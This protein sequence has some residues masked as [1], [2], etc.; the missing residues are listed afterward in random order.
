MKSSKTIWSAYGN[1]FKNYFK[2]SGRASRYDFWAFKIIDMLIVL[3]LFLFSTLAPIFA[4]VAGVYNLATIFPALALLSRRLHDRG[5]SFWLWGLVVLL[6]FGAGVFS[7]I[8][9]YR[10]VRLG[11]GTIVFTILG[12]AAVIVSVYIFFQT[13]FKSEQAANKYGAAVK[14]TK[15]YE[16]RA[17]WYLA[18]YLLFAFLGAAAYGGLIAYY[19][20]QGF[21]ANVSK[22]GEQIQIL[23][24][25]IRD[26][27]N[28]D[29]NGLSPMAAVQLNLVPEDMIGEEYLINPFG[30]PV[31]LEGHGDQFV[32]IY[33]GV[34][35]KAC[36]RLNALNLGNGFSQMLISAGR[37]KS[38]DQCPDARCD[39]G[40]FFK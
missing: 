22:A 21:E 25:N 12:F 7:A 17:K 30:G 10:G 26:A 19:A 8:D 3:I 13:C 20:N 38:C 39:M 11:F 15:Q 27:G 37:V 6:I 14:E 31:E 16:T 24:K 33:Y 5:K 32:I 36:E 18:A 34:P 40:W 9:G 4:G 2:F 35:A 28:G 1:A 29:Y 23:Q